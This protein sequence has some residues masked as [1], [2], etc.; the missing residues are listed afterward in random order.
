MGVLAGAPPGAHQLEIS[1]FGPGRGEAIV[2]HLG[3]DNWG[4]IDSCLETPGGAPAALAY[5]DGIGVGRDRVRF[6]FATHWHDDHVL[7]LA[8]TLES[9]PTAEFGCSAAYTAAEFEA[10]TSEFPTNLRAPL[11]EMRRCFSLIEARPPAGPVH[12][13]PLRIVGRSTVWSSDNGEVTLTA[14]APTPQAIARAQDS[15]ANFLLPLAKKRMTGGAMTPNHGSVVISLHTP[16]QAVLLGGDLEETGSGG[17]GWSSVILQLLPTY[18]RAEVFKVP[19]HGSAGSHHDEQ[20]TRLL[21]QHPVSL[22][23]AYSPSRLPRESDL[24]RLARMS[25]SLLFAGGKRRHEADLPGAE[26]TAM[27]ADGVKIESQGEL[28]H[29]RL[30]RRLDGS[31]DWRVELSSGAQE[32]AET[33]SAVGPLRPARRRARRARR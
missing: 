15:I 7:G 24:N 16:G 32:V 28:G 5:L 3:D 13:T 33:P 17:A 4:I 8:E 12:H 20:W 14:L 9:C 11:Q 22:V 29:L 30:R 6:V 1:V 23:T 26:R 21:E 19:H 18:R 2:L 27:A 31:G 25:R 10:L